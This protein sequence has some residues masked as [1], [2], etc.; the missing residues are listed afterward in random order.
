MGTYDAVCQGC[1]DGNIIRS[2][3][4]KKKGKKKEKSVIFFNQYDI[5]NRI[6]LGLPWIDAVISSAVKTRTGTPSLRYSRYCGATA[7]L[8]TAMIAADN[9]LRYVMSQCRTKQVPLDDS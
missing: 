5:T 6:S 2:K 3:R 1:G 7:M 8:E 4:K 9:I